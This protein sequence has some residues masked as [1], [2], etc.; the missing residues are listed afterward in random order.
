MPATSQ[1]K[2]PLFSWLT[3]TSMNA[4]HLFHF[5][6]LHGFTLRKRGFSLKEVAVHLNGQTA[7]SFLMAV[8]QN[9]QTAMRKVARSGE[10]AD[11]NLYE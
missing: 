11:S 4:S 3:L 5:V 7:T 8:H 2:A 10:V 1:A 6:P 9:G